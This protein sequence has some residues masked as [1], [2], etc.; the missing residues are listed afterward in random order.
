MVKVYFATNRNPNRQQKPD[1]FGANF[2]GA[3]LAS[4]RFGQAEVSGD[5]LDTYVVQVARERLVKDA[6]RKQKD[7][8]GSTLGSQS[9]FEHARRKMASTARDTVIFIH[10]YNVSFKE[11][12]TA[13][14]R[15]KLNFGRDA[16][17]PG[18]NIVL[19]SWPSDGLMMPFLAYANDR[20]DAAASGPAFA[21]G[22]LNWQSSCVVP[23]RKKPVISAFILSLT[24]WAT[25]SFAT[26]CRRSRCSLP[27]GRRG[28]ST[29]F[30]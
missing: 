24:A 6:E 9:V 22:L 7:G 14:S 13:A 29:K 18:V 12:L 1:D 3:G 11:A 21:R 27:V 23:R 5:E 25:T 19:F 8:T 2:S 26:L 28:S 20:Q 30:S 15:L 4:L 10:G 17:G 16:G